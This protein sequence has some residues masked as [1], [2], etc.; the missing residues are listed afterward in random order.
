MLIDWIIPAGLD[1]P[2][3]AYIAATI[4]AV[5]ITGIA[6]GGFGGVGV[7]ATP[8]MMMVAPAGLVL[9]MLLPILIVADIATIR[10]YPREWQWRP[11]LPIAPWTILGVVVGWF[12][13]DYMEGRGW[14][15]KIFV[16]VLSLGF[17]LLEWTRAWLMRRLKGQQVE[18]KWQPNWQTAAP[19]GLG[20]GV[21]TMLAHAAGPFTTIY[22][23]LQGLDR[24]TFV[25]TTARYYFVL[26]SLKIPF[27]VNLG[28]ITADTL[29]KSIWLLPVIPLGVW[30]GATLNKRV[31]NNAFRQIMYVLL[32]L[33]GAYLLYDN[34]WPRLADWDTL[35]KE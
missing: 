31:S 25:G 15:I 22:F 2:V 6:K 35:S 30:L 34:L 8:L 3:A 4:A 26:N 32:A 33:T 17:A 7:L 16:G 28:L 10:T 20:A 12:L 1:T 24:R 13:L 23:L 29:T 9:G 5:L 19:F 27:Q 14:M 21:A 11:L 18:D